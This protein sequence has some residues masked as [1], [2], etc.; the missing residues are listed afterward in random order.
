MTAIDRSLRYLISSDADAAYRRY[1]VAGITR[2]RVI[3]SLQRFRQLLLKSNSPTELNAA[4][5]RE[6]VFYQSTGKDTKGSVLFTAYFEPVY[7]A[8]RVPTAEYRYPIY[9]LPDDLNSWSK[10]HPTRLELEGADGLLVSK[11]RLR[12]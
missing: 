11:G 3:N 5:A 8:S 6:F 10:P 9:R 12:G 1:K 7:A 4:I 2:N